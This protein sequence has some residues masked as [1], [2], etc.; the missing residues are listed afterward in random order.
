MIIGLSVIILVDIS[1]LGYQG[2]ANSQ[3]RLV[4]ADLTYACVDD[5]APHTQQL[6]KTASCLLFC[7]TNTHLSWEQVHLVIISPRLNPLR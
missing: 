2:L 7:H 1:S 3:A 4:A 5:A 6:G